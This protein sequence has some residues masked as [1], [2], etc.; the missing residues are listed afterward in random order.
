MATLRSFVRVFSIACLLE[1]IAPSPSAWVHAQ[2]TSLKEQFLKEYVPAAAKLEAFYTKLTMKGTIQDRRKNNLEKTQDFIF[3][4][5]KPNFVNEYFKR[6]AEEAPFLGPSLI[7]AVNREESFGLSKALGSSNYKRHGVPPG[8][9]YGLQSTRLHNAAPFAPYCFFEATIVDFIKQN[10]VRV[11]SVTKESKGSAEFTRLTF[12]HPNQK[13]WFVFWP[14][15]SWAL[16]EFGRHGTNSAGDRRVATYEGTTDGVPLL[17]SF[18][19][20]SEDAPWSQEFFVST[21]TVL[22]IVPGAVAEEEFQLSRF[23]RDVDIRRIFLQLLVNLPLAG[24]VA[25]WWW[26]TYR[27][28]SRIDPEAIASTARNWLR[29]L[30]AYK[31]VSRVLGAFLLVAALLKTYQLATSDIE[32]N[33]GIN[34]RTVIVGVVALEFAFG[35]WLLTNHRAAWSRFAAIALFVIFYNVS[36][37]Q[38]LAGQGS[39]ACLGYVGLNPWAMAAIDLLAFAGLLFAGLPKEHMAGQDVPSRSNLAIVLAGYLLLAIPAMASMAD[40]SPRSPVGYLRNDPD[41]LLTVQ[42]DLKNPTTSQVAD[43]L[44]KAT[45]LSFSIDQT[46]QSNSPDFGRLGGG[47]AWSIMETLAERQ[48]AL[49][50]WDKTGNGY[51][52]TRASGPMPALIGTCLALALLMGTIIWNV[53]QKWRS[54]AR[55]AELGTNPKIGSSAPPRPAFTLMELVVVLAILGILMAL[56]IPAIQMVRAAAAR[57]ECANKLRQIALA[58]HSFHDDHKRM[59][60]AFGFFPKTDIFSGGNGLGNLF[61][62]LLPYIQQEGLYEKS[63]Y[64]PAGKPKQDYFFYTANNVHQQQVP[65]FNCPSDPTLMPGVNPKTNYAPSSYAANYLVF[66]NVWPA[67]SKTGTGPG[68]AGGQ[69]PFSNKNAQGRPVMPATFQDGMSN[70]L[71]FAEK[72]GSAFIT[73]EANQG[74]GKDG[75]AHL[76]GCHWA[77]FQADCHNPFFAYYDPIPKKNPFTDPNAV[78]S[79]QWA[80]GSGQ[81]S[82]IT[83]QIQPSPNGGSNPC[84][85]ATGHNAMNAAMADGTVRSLAAGMDRRIWWALVTPAGRDRAE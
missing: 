38:G 13:G 15:Q 63:R 10:D 42:M 70:T 30:L 7:R 19:A 52:L 56:L 46:L 84:M 40:Y 34:S 73:A 81:A 48:F 2:N 32:D 5:N 80:G 69:S 75:R 28:R 31:V 44:A 74:P 68:N 23:P 53:R 78:G 59:P 54:G 22:E 24:T 61:F 39:C 14:A 65:L 20:I 25:F 8:Y 82:G 47:P 60:P 37:H 4:A 67:G 77:Y 55:T 66:G 51:H 76:G 1:V 72:Y 85:P 16:T 29:R 41:L 64:Q 6:G 71:L 27:R 57:T 43:H 45:G 62:H 9:T 33:T 36:I 21:Y 49:S 18:E 11:V 83:F 17:K 58:C 3:K 12:E 79:G 35:I 26:I 50:R